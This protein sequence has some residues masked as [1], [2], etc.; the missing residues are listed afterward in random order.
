MNK[1]K[2][3]ANDSLATKTTKNAKKKPL[4][5]EMNM[6]RFKLMELQQIRDDKIP[7]H[8][9]LPKDCIFYKHFMQVDTNQKIQK[10]ADDQI[11]EDKELLQGIA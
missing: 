8:E 2:V 6:L 10:A 11:R 5:E 3:I 9:K 4:V 1:I 7:D